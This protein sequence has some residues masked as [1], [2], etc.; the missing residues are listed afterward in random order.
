VKSLNR[1]GSLNMAETRTNLS[2]PRFVKSDAILIVGLKKRYNDATSA[3]IP[4][5]WRAFQPHIGN[6]EKQKGNVAFGVVCNNDDDGNFD[7]VT[8]VEVSQFSDVAKELEGIRILP[9]TYATFRHAGHVSEIK[10]TWTAIFGLPRGNCPIV[11]APKFER[12]GDSFNPQTGYGD[13]E[14]WIPINR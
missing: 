10:Q 13:I 9:Q 2:S 5:H 6:I 7:Y 11:D 4:A 12:Y 8:G 1:V 3:E 14:I